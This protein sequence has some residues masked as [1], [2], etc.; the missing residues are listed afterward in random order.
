MPKQKKIASKQANQWEVDPRQATF[1]AVYLD[2]KS[3]TFGNGLQSAISAGYTESYA[4]VMVSEMPDWL[5]ENLN[6]LNLVE[7]AVKNLNEQLDDNDK[8]AKALK[9]DAT[10][11]TLQTL[12]K[13]KFSS[14]T[15]LTG[16]EGKD[17]V[18]SSKTDEELKAIIINAN[19]VIGETNGTN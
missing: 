4:A 6:E 15:E 10:K 16:A 14:R 11:F 8:K 2:P 9:W 1:L 7:K 19:K 17:L 13:G 12:H 5:S 3:P 18:F